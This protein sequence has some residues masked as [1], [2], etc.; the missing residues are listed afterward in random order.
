MG[1]CCAHGAFETIGNKLMAI[2][3]AYIRVVG[4]IRRVGALDSARALFPMVA[5]TPRTDD[6]SING[7]PEARQPSIIIVDC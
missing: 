6:G 3:A 7:D 2:Q 4:D 5:T 1:Q